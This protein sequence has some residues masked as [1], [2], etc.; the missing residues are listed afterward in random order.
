MANKLETGNVITTKEVDYL[1]QD[2]SIRNQNYVCLSFI[3]PED[4]LKKKEHFFFEKYVSAFVKKNQEFTDVL[5]NLFPD[6]KDEIRIL[7]D[8]FEYLF[9]E[10][11]IH[12]NFKHFV[13]DNESV[14]EKEFYEKNA[15]QTCIRGIKVRGTYDTLEEA[16]ARSERLRK[17]DGNKFSIYV[18]QVGCWCPWSPNPDSIADQEFAES[19]LNTL[20]ARYKENQDNKDIHFKE[21]QAHMKEVIVENEQT[22]KE[23]RDAEKA[24]VETMGESSSSSMLQESELPDQSDEDPWT[25]QRVNKGLAQENL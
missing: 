9:D 24:D 22:R 10:G 11:K 7:K 18:A 23:T 13:Q 12:D 2:E 20:M 17:H 16:K 25:T 4:V 8:N 1:E 14:V 5:H 19:A 21:R 15:F 3:S 6:K